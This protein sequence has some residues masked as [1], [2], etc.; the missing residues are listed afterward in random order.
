MLRKVL[1]LF[2]RRQLNLRSPRKIRSD[3]AK[4]Q[5]PKRNKDHQNFSGG[6]QRQLERVSE[7]GETRLGPAA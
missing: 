5:R 4:K 6:Q 7:A 1:G 3:S 2:S